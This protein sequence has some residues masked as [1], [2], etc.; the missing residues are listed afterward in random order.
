MGTKKIFVA[1]SSYIYAGQSI[2]I[3]DERRGGRAQAI[4]YAFQI[5]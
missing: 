2:E 5:I 4:P 3:E 1:L